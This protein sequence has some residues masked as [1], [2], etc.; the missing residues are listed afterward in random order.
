[1]IFPSP[2]S[3]KMDI[4]S[5]EY[6]DFSFIY[7]K[8]TRQAIEYAFEKA[9]S[10]DIVDYL[11]KADIESLHSCDDEKII[12]WKNNLRELNIDSFSKHN[13]VSNVYHIFKKG[14]KSFIRFYLRY[15]TY[16]YPISIEKEYV[17]DTFSDALIAIKTRY[18]QEVYISGYCRY[19]H[20]EQDEIVGYYTLTNRRKVFNKYSLTESD[21]IEL[22]ALINYV[23]T[24]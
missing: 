14:W 13:L 12:L 20:N 1:M 6:G 8:L 4:E 19:I 21:I 7:D 18:L 17:N 2:Q 5:I 23:A 15:Q 11:E 22:K 24:Y 16:K 10:L 9:Y 3:K